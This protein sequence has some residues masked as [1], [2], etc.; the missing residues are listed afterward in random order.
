MGRE[1]VVRFCPR[2]GMSYNYISTNRVNGHTYYYAVHVVKDGAKRRVHKCYLGAK[3]YVYVRL[4]HPE[5]FENMTGMVDSN[6]YIRYLEDIINVLAR[7]KL[8]DSQ[9]RH[10]K[11]I[12]EEGLRTIETL[13]P[14]EET[15]SSKEPKSG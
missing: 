10:I 6:R 11:G 2:C 8:D 14:P 5:M 13:E 1:R 4:M 9:R 12:L 3:D 7:S 15:P